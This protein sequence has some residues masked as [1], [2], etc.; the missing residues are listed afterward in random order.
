MSDTSDYQLGGGIR[1]LR[2]AVPMLVLM[3][4]SVSLNAQSTV[5]YRD[6]SFG[7]TPTATPTGEKPES[8]LWFNDGLWWGSMFNTNTSTYHIYRFNAASQSWTD[9]G[10]QLDNRPSTKADCLWDGSGQKLYVASHVFTTNGSVTSSSSQWGRVYRYSYHSSTQ[11][12]TLDSG[13]PVTV[14]K[15]T[16]ETL[17]IAKDT[18]GVLWVT[19]TQGS[20][21]YVNHS[22][23]G[24]DT[25]WGTPFLVPTN[26]NNTTLSSDDISSLIAFGPGNIGVMWSNQLTTKVYFMVHKDGDADTVWQPEETAFPLPGGT[27]TSDD[28]INLKTDNTGR[29]FA[30]VKTSL[31]GSTDPLIE[32]IVR[33]TNGTWSNYVFGR[34]ADHHSRPIVL[35]DLEHSQVYMFAVSPEGGTPQAIYYKTA[36]LNAISFPPG[37]GTAFIK[38][39]TDV[40]INNASSTKQNVDSSTGL[41]VIS[42]DQNTDHYQHNFLPLGGTQPAVSISSFTPTSGVVGTVVTLNGSGFTGTTSVTFNGISASFSFVT[43]SKLKAIVPAGATTGPIQVIAPAGTGISS[44]NFVVTAPPSITSFTPTSGP[45]GTSVTIT[46]SNFTGTTGVSF[47]GVAASFTLNS[48]TKITATVPAG[49]QSGVIQVTNSA[50][51]GTSSSNF[52]VTVP[53][54]IT[55]FTPTSGPVGTSVTITGS[56]FTGASAVTFAGAAASFTVNS[57]TQITATVPTGATTGPIQ[58]KSS[59][60]TGSS[61]SNFVVTVPPSIT[62]FTPKSGPV[63]T[64][65]TLRGSGFTGTT[66]VTFNGVSA[67]FNFI[68]DSRLTAVVPSGATTGPIR[69]TNP[70]GTATSSTNFVVQ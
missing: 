70:G 63:G 18:T 20:K 42:S 17:V 23:V 69:V 30:A 2:V 61:S 44:S 31:T 67:A 64:V 40:N 49:A 7:T 57:S 16:S 8:K 10:T 13:F 11:S 65:V 3:L 29:V 33:A 21:V 54:T 38:N 19:F 25:Q 5:G 43:D 46:G 51:T 52:V 27:E 35:L 58:V 62:S 28:H 47:A 59:G 56:G 34:K 9:T 48:D 15:G 53:P 45:A 41:L 68:K 1:I 26:N 55:S 39:S 14:N 37:L 24:N 12:Y 4:T 50:G 22:A 66:S 6:F 60:G 32:L 36:S